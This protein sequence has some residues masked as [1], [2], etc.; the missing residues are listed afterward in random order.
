MRYRY[1]HGVD[2][3]DW[4]KWDAKAGALTDAEKAAAAA[5]ADNF[6]TAAD[7][8]KWMDTDTSA[9]LRLRFVVQY[10]STAKKTAPIKDLTYI[11][12]FATP[13]PEPEKAKETPWLLYAAGAAVLFLLL[14]K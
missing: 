12:S 3:Y 9:S 4:S 14:R 5:I 11:T 13:D 8:Q 1:M 7:Y 10:A 6:K 2:D